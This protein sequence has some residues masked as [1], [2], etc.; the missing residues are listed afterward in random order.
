[1]C[2]IHMCHH[3]AAAYS[4]TLRRF[5][6][7]D[8][9]LYVGCLVPLYAFQPRMPDLVHVKRSPFRRPVIIPLV[10]EQFLSVLRTDF[11][12]QRNVLRALV[13][14]ECRTP[15]LFVVVVLEL[16]CIIVKFCNYL[17]PFQYVPL[18]SVLPGFFLGVLRNSGKK[19]FLAK[20]IEFHPH[21]FK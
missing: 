20:L 2:D 19:P 10:H 21:E 6:K 14:A 13:G 18:L 16:V 7:S 15:V 9:R 4:S 17:V 8:V 1:M 11:T 12:E 5:C 3:A